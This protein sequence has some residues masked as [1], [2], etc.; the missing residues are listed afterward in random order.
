MSPSPADE[1]RR[2]NTRKASVLQ[3]GGFRPTFD[4][5]A[6]NFGMAPLGLPGE[7]W[8]VWNSKPLL[9]VCQINLATAP[10]VPAL[11]AD[12]KLLTFFID[13]DLGEVSRENGQEWVVRA[14][15]FLEG[16]TR[17]ATPANAPKVK[18]GF[19]CRWEECEDHPNADDPE[20]VTVKGARRPRSDFDN[21]ARTKVGGYATTI[22]SEPWWG[23]D[24]HPAA[25]KF[26]VQVNSEEKAGLVWGDGGAIYI[27]R[28]T[29][30]GCED[31]WFL[32]W[33]QF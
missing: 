20:T 30:P 1:Y 21:V 23:H 27:A 33:Q 6:S 4:P 13:P 3:V 8:P 17:I 25:P 2:L 7:E 19:E 9:F 16:L 31:Q 29:A 10:A 24:A 5:A 12:I 18:K 22:Q 14:Y 11:L 28:G 26:C 15:P 32:D